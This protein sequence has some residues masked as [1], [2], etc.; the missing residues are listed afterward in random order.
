MAFPL[1]EHF[2]LS[3]DWR[4]GRRRKV[5]GGLFTGLDQGLRTAKGRGLAQN[6]A[7]KFGG[8]KVGQGTW[9]KGRSQGLRPKGAN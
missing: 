3:E 4:I 5:M 8:L 7:P 9:G 1:R 2:K 6:L